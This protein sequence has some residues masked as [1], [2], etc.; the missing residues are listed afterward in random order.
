MKNALLRLESVGK[1]FAGRVALQNVS[2]ALAAGEILTLLG[3]SGCGKTTILRLIAE[4]AEP[5]SGTIKR[6]GLLDARH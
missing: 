6:A 3:P 5:D 2:L 1:T 4:L